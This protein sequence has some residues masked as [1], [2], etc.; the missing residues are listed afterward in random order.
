MQTSNPLADI[1]QMT[2]KFVEI[3][4]L[5]D[6]Q[7]NCIP[8]AATRWHD[9]G[10]RPALGRPFA[11]IFRHPDAFLPSFFASPWISSAYAGAGLRRNSSI[12]RRISRNRFRGTAISANWN[13]TYRPWRTTLAPILTSF[14]RSVVTDQCSTSFSKA[15]VRMKLPKFS[16]RQTH[17]SCRF[18]LAVDFLGLRRSESWSQFID[19]PQDF[20]KQV[21][22]YGDFG[23]LER[24]VP[25]MADNIDPLTSFSRSVVSDQC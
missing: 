20:P 6:R 2:S 18:H 22:G 8:F 3:V 23:Q 9:F 19:P 10:Y 13:V 21:P 16:A 7:G 11:R 12:R 25:A 15:N 1:L 5:S 24:D 17:P 4:S 14:S